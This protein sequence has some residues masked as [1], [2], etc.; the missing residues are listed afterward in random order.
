[1]KF[2]LIIAMTASVAAVLVP[3]LTSAQ[4]NNAT[5][6]ILTNNVYFLSTNLYP[7]WGQGKYLIRRFLAVE[8]T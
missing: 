8:K 1:M 6:S 4:S 5:L 7:N 2:T 3:S